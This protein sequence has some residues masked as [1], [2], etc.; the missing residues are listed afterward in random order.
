MNWR[1]L[2]E[3]LSVLSEDEIQKLLREE[4][5]DGKR[6]SIVIRLHQRF[7]MMR[8]DRERQELLGK[9]VK[10]VKGCPKAA[11]PAQPPS[12]LL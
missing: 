5:R 8:A 3:K 11:A 2:N 4:M 6:A 1:E 9:L 12:G 10:P 7:T